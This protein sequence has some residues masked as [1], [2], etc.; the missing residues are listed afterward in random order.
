MIT[1]LSGEIH[2][3]PPLTWEEI[4]DGP[5]LADLRLCLADDGED[6]RAYDAAVPA[7]D[8]PRDILGELQALVDA[9]GE[10]HAFAGHIEVRDFGE[11]WRLAVRDGRAVRIE[12]PLVWPEEDTEP[13]IR[14]G[15]GVCPACDREVKVTPV[16]GVMCAHRDQDGVRCE[17]RG[18]RPARITVG[19]A[20]VNRN[21]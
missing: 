15:R 7:T 11:V 16:G 13:T 21:T 10:S 6:A 12:P 18:R 19:A 5:P 14:Y 4:V 2:I 3:A 8:H 9:H 17:G 1:D 20:D